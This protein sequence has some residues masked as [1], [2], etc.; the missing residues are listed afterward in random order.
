MTANA[1]DLTW[2]NAV[3]QRAGLGVSADAVGTIVATPD[4]NDVQAAITAFSQWLLNSS[5]VATLNS[6]A[7]LDEIYNGNGNNRMFL[8]NP[9]IKSLIA[10]TGTNFVAPL[11]TDVNTLGVF[12][13]SGKASI[14]IR[15]GSGV[16]NYPYRTGF[17]SDNRGPVFPRGTGNLRVQYTGGYDPVLVHNEIDTITTQSITLQM[18]PWQADSA[19]LFYPSLVSLVNVANSPAAGQYAVSN[20][21]YVFNATDNTKQV[22][23]SYYRLAAPADLEYSVRCVVAINYKRKGWQDLATQGSSA[24]GTNA[25]TTYRNWA[26]PPEHQKVF[27]FYTRTAII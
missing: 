23:V 15:C 16:V 26:W 20:G 8:R 3:K 17:R 24:G 10:I 21:L 1:I 7:T 12:V 27:E 6:I 14:A 18:G 25:T 22:A 5:S 11:S 19:V 13:E 2:L 4:D 9:P